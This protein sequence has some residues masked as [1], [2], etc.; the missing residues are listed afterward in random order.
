MALVCAVFENIRNLA[1][2]DSCETDTAAAQQH[3][4]FFPN[5][6]GVGGVGPARPTVYLSTYPPSPSLYTG[7]VVITSNKPSGALLEEAPYATVCTCTMSTSSAR[8]V[9][10]KLE[11]YKQSKS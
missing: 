1:V 3:Y 11:R 2:N 10:E 5:R 9:L 4:R 8:H 6:S 7:R